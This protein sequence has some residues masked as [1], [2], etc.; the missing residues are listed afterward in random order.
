M[1]IYVNK[2]C[3]KGVVPKSHGQPGA[4]EALRGYRKKPQ[5][6]LANICGQHLPGWMG[7]VAKAGSCGCSSGGA[8]IRWQQ[9]QNE[10]ER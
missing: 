7:K 5:I 6:L 10:A 9:G 3:A 8:L 4:G 2:G 1:F